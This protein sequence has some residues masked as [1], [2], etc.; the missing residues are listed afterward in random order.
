MPRVTDE[1]LIKL[2]AYAYGGEDYQGEYHGTY[3]DAK[4]NI[5]QEGAFALVGG[6]SSDMFYA[7]A[8][9]LD[10]LR[11]GIRNLTGMNIAR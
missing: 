11:Q 6:S 3:H 8:I 5:E 9:S 1:D 2:L 10:R 7:P 4:A